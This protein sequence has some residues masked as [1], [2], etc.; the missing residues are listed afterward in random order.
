MRQNIIMRAA[1]PFH[2]KFNERTVS[3]GTSPATSRISGRSEVR[4]PLVTQSRHQ[5]SSIMQNNHQNKTAESGHDL[6]SQASNTIEV[7]PTKRDSFSRSITGSI[8]SA[9]HLDFLLGSKV[10]HVDDSDSDSSDDDNDESTLERLANDDDQSLEKGRL[11]EVARRR[12]LI[13]RG[14]FKMSRKKYQQNIQKRK[15]DIH[16]VLE[17]EFSFQK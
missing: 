13:S 16:N 8:L 14:R 9:L 2:E 15:K 10:D 17:E 7:D 11:R 3:E 5:F 12:E 6:Q 4:N 1:K